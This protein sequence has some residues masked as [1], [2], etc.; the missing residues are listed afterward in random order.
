MRIRDFIRRTAVG[1]GALGVVLSLTG[2][3]LEQLAREQALHRYRVPG[4]LV[5][6]GGG[7]RIQIDCRGAGSPTVVLESGLDNYGSL[8]WAAVHDAIATRNRVCAYSRAGIMW[9]DPVAAPFDSRRVASDLHA[10]LLGAGEHSPWVLVGHSLGGP[11]I[12]TF[13]QQYPD[14]VAGL[15]FVDATH[16]DQ[17]T[18]YEAA[19]GKSIQPT[20][21]LARVGAAAAWTGL[22]RLLPTAPQSASWPIVLTSVAPAFLPTSLDELADELDALDSTLARAG[23]GRALGDRPVVVLS[24][25]RVQSAEQLALSGLSADKGAPLL[26]AHLALAAYM[27][28]WSSRARLE[29][30]RDASHYIQFDRPDA[31]V[32]AVTE[33]TGYLAGHAAGDRCR[34]FRGVGRW[35]HADR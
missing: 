23:A 2:A 31:V 34:R 10:A 8:S 18:R 12:T 28:T 15:V 30:V 16:P 6:V 35:L 11:Y 3:V 20:A 27:A 26:A 7:R 25:G 9:S 21:T 13:T 17:F 14:E 1:A 19:V 24:A 32:S 5:D 22:L 33:V 4:R 29:V